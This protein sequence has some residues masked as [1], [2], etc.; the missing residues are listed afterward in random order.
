[1]AEQCV[2]TGIRID[3]HAVRL[4]AFFVLVLLGAFILLASP[5]V[6]VFLLADFGLRAFRRGRL[7]PLL[8]LSR[9]GLRLAG[10]PPKPVDAGPKLFAARL[11]LGFCGLLCA[12]A[13]SPE[14]AA[15]L[16]VAVLFALP[17]VL[18]SFFGYC[19]GCKIHTLIRNAREAGARQTA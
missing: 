3:E 1:M 11:G 7:S 12:L 16:V 19:V 2:R 13:F 6:A 9:L 17:V 4:N 15:A 14:R 8:S 5:W 18:E 10:R